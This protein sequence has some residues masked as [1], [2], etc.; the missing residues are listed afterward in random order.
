MTVSEKVAYIKGLADGLQLSKD[1]PEGKVLTAI[2]DVLEDVSY[3]LSDLED[4]ITVL[5]DDIDDLYE[6]EYDED[7]DFDDD[8]END[9]DDLYEV[10]CSKCGEKIFLDIDDLEEG[11]IVCPACGENLEFEIPECECEDCSGCD[12]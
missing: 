10:T 2:L 5:S 12:N 8:D 1:T 4:S 3:A 7:E 6:D 9:E 11:G